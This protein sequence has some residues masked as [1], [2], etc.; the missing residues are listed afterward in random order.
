MNIISL[1]A[2][3]ALVLAIVLAP[4]FVAL[5][6]RV[7]VST[8]EVH[9]VQSA[10]RTVSYGK[11]ETAGNTYYKWPAFF[12]II[13]VRTSMLPMSVFDVDLDSYAAYDKGRLPFQIDIMAFFRIT[14]SNLAAQRVHKFEELADQLKGILQGACRTILASSQIEEILEGRSQFGEMF[15]KEVDHQLVQWG[16]QSVKQIE[17]MDIRDAQG[18][19]V[20][21]NIM[22]KK[23]SEI[24]KESR[25]AVAENKRAAEVAEVEAAQAI[26][27][28]KQEAE[29]LVGVRTA[30]KEQQVGISA[31]VA[32]Q[33]VKEQEAIT[34]AKFM[35]VKRV[36]TIKQ[37]EID[38]DSQVVTADQDA[39]TTIRRAEGD[40]QAAK[41]AAEA[42]TVQGAAEGA[43]K[44]AV[45]MAPV[46][47]QIALAKEIG[48]NEGYQKYLLSNRTIEKEQ[49]VGIAQADALKAAEIK[50]IA[51][52]G[53]VTS[54]VNSITDL[55]SANGGTQLGAM[56][57]A[58]AQTPVG[59]AIKNRFLNGNG[60]EGH[61]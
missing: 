40:L 15:T 8:N 21:Q 56:V 12:P 31:Q 36:E 10:K 1:G 13:G 44:Q 18:S 24:D 61:A 38:R 25:V 50:V 57:E 16:V 46:N 45:L 22:A 27:L 33:A 53:N 49:A 35:E 42:V 32:A 60:S 20:I 54:G 19:V 47:T 6:F 4:I 7:V 59:A 34:A 37:A 14:D 58:L 17:L 3:G 30:Q 52:S 28:R 11:G 41:L 29:Q 43:A 5:C 2:I 9:I 48:T 26:A 51:N 39:K 23:K 55:L